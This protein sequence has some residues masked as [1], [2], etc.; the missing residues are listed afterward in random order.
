MTSR[1]ITQG[2]YVGSDGTS[3]ACYRALPDGPSK[4]I[5]QIAH[6]MGEHF[7]RYA[8]LTARLT[9][10]GY[11]V[12]ASDHRGHGQSASAHGLG[13]FGPGGFQAVVDDMAIVS[14]WAKQESPGQPL[15]LLA[16][17]MGS[18]ASQLYLLQHASK[19]AGLALS[20][21][22]ALD[23]LLGQM[24]ASGGPPSLA[25]LNATFEPARTPFDWLS[26]DEAEVDAYLADPL[27]GFDIADASMQSMFMLGATARMDPRLTD[28]PKSLPVHVI[29]GGRDPV[30]GPDQ[31]FVEALLDSYRAAGLTE[32][33][34]HVYSGGRHEMFN[35][36]NHTQVEDEVID[37]LNG[38]VARA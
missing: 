24:L 30:T 28:V 7:M 3:L 4:G 33:E 27:C 15:V 1:A 5:V 2:T 26:R 19:L 20:G 35:E 36:T 32:I 10:A 11:T 8:R 38:V 17:S 23:Q 9:N 13:E 29:S 21:T 25:L 18:F 12:Y 31:V 16:H 14:D 37:W 34:H 22:T 6:G